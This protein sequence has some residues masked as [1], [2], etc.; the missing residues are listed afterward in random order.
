MEVY[1]LG[2]KLELQLLAYTT[3]M[4]MPDL[5]HIFDL[6]HRSGQCQILNPLSEVRDQTLNLVAPSWICFHC[7]MTGTLHI[8]FSL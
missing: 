8:E 2:V 6:Y 1:R 4:A 7:A 3:A 5:S